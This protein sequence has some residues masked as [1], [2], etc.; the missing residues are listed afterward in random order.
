MRTR[1]VRPD[2]IARS[3]F[4]GFL[5]PARRHGRRSPLVPALRPV[6]RDIE[7]LLTERR[8]EVDHVTV[9]RWVVR[10]APLLAEAARPCRHA[11]GDRWQGR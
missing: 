2:P 5:L 6:Y 3:A 4:A 11:I 8:I 10:F 1:R 7:E 9:Y